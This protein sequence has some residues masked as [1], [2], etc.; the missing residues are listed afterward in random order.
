MAETVPQVNLDRALTQLA[1][2]ATRRVRNIYL[3]DHAFLV[4]FISHFLTNLT[5]LVL[6]STLL[7]IEGINML[8]STLLTI[9]GI[10]MLLSTLLT[11]EG[12]NMLL[13]TLL[14][15]EGINS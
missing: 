5:F 10:N 11:I 9:E 4:D 14:T 15:I 1:Q 7:T 12:I 13:S 2:A 8:L 3:V 6:L